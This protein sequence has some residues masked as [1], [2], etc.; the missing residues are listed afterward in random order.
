MVN[1][2]NKG[3]TGER[4]FANLVNTIFGWDKESGVRRTPCSGAL[5]SF[6]GDLIQLKGALE[7]FHFEVKNEKSVRMPSYHRQAEADCSFDKTPIVGYKMGGKWYCSLEAGAL[8]QLIKELDEYRTIRAS[9][10]YH[11]EPDID[12]IVNSLMGISKGI[13]KNENI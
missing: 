10:K 5:S 8:L 6:K 1:S 12:A 11:V 3:K 13:I 4:E 7:K 2:I 9:Q